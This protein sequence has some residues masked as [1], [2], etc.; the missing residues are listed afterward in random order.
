MGFKI[1]NVRRMELRLTV[2][3]IVRRIGMT[4]MCK[5]LGI[6]REAPRKWYATG[7]PGRHWMRLVQ[8][9]A[10]LTY[11]ILEDATAMAQRAKARPSRKAA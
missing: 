11:E 6:G 9:N 10:W 7:I 8:A 4:K 3:G 2:K 1:P 5:Q